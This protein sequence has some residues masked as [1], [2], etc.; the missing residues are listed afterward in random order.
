MNYLILQGIL[1]VAVYILNTFCLVSLLR[2]I[3]LGRV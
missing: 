3:G 1:G 2:E